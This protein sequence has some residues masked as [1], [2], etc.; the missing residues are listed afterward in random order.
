MQ[1]DPVCGMQL[2][3]GVATTMVMNAGTLY[4]F[5]SHECAQIFMMRPEAYISEKYCASP[6]Q[7]GSGG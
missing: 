3:D 4:F 7:T 1:E 2:G 6:C 5:C